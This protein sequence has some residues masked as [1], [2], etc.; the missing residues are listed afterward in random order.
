MS[1]LLE[2]LIDNWKVC[3]FLR[4]KGPNYLYCYLDFARKIKN[5]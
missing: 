1:I 3:V 2:N 4:T 5:T